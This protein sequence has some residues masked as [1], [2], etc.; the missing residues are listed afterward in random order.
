[1]TKSDREIVEI[2]EAYD[3]TETGWS[4]AALTGHDP[5]A[6]RQALA[7][8]A[9]A[10]GASAALLQLF[11]GFGQDFADREGLGVVGTHD[12]LTV[13]SGLFE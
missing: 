4:A 8:G 12:Q 7:E 13:D 5:G 3:L 10:S 11:L 6:L 9:G 2:F 1:M